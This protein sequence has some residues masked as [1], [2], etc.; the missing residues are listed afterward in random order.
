MRLLIATLVVIALA[1]GAIHLL[2]GAVNGWAADQRDR[3][4]LVRS[5]GSWTPPTDNPNIH[6]QVAVRV[7][8]S[9]GGR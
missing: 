7:P 5:G 2:N 3:A 8:A 9:G 4:E 1:V 6:Y